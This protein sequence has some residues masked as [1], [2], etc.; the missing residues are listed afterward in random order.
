MNLCSSRLHTVDV[1]F[2]DSALYCLIHCFFFLPMLAPIAPQSSVGCVTGRRA[3]LGSAG[4]SP[5]AIPVLGD[6]GHLGNGWAFLLML[7]E[8]PGHT[9]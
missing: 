8:A 5:L 3:L 6:T 1:C 7:T 4:A 2:S 9:S